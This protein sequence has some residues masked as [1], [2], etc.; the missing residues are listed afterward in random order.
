MSC[1]TQNNQIKP[2]RNGKSSPHKPARK[3]RTFD[4]ASSKLDASP[5]KQT[6]ISKIMAL[7]EQSANMMLKSEKPLRKN[8][9]KVRVQ[10]S[11]HSMY[12]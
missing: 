7:Q 6:L 5:T 1:F 8:E 2:S 10:I 4:T 12:V 11:Y 9:E 3:S